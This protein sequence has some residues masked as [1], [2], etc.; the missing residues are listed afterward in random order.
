MSQLVS[1]VSHAS[2]NE[3]LF[4]LLLKPD[5]REMIRQTIIET[6]FHESADSIRGVIDENHQV[7]AI[8]K[9]LLKRAEE[10][11]AINEKII[12]ATPQRS[13]AFR[14][15]I[16]NLYNFTCV[17]CRL[18]IITLDGKTAVD[19]AHIIP[20]EISRDDGIGNGLALC[21][22]HHWAFDN[23]LISLDDEYKLIVSSAFE[24]SGQ[25]SFLLRKLRD[26]TILLPKQKPFFPSLYSV[27][28]HRKKWF[29]K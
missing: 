28:W 27:H 17:A 4:V 11:K 5:T 22:L 24:E 26:K 2:L 10:A 29:Q 8:E 6:Y 14:G 23:G 7:S 3:D 13:K 15:V 12:P 18:R 1:V 25:E 9:M 19:A 21:K 16:M 20:F